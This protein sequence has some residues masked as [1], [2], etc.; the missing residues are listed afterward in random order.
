MEMVGRE[1]QKTFYV[2]TAVFYLACEL[3]VCKNLAA[4]ESCHYFS[5]EVH[6][7]CFSPVFTLA[8][9]SEMTP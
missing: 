3:V 1:E 7:T 6:L 8:V 4:F 9:S 2:D 5:V